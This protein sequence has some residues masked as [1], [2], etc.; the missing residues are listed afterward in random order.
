[1]KKASFEKATPIWLKGLSQEMNIQAWFRAVFNLCRDILGV[2]FDPVAK[3]VAFRPPAVDLDWC[4]GLIPVG[5]ERIE[6]KWSR[7]GKGVWELY[8]FAV[9][10]G[11]RDAVGA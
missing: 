1:M 6:A 8:R 9:A 11:A 7:D 4:E 5:N 3:T 2:H 10:I